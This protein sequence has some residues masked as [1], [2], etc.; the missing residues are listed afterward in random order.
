VL[1]ALAALAIAACGGETHVAT[2]VGSHTFVDLVDALPADLDETGTPDNASTQ[3]VPNWMSELVRTATAA[4]GPSTVLPTG[5]AVVPYLATSWHALANGDYVFELRHAARGA[6]GDPLTAADVRWSLERAVARSPVAPFLFRLARIDS[7]NPVTILSAHSVR[8]NVSGPSPFTLSVLADPDAAIYDSRLMRSHASA[9]DPWAQTW[10]STHSATFGAYYVAT[11]LPNREISLVANPGFWRHPYY[12]HVLIKEVG[13][14]DERV[15]EVLAGTAT[16][17]AGL[18]WGSFGTAVD[19]GPGDGVTATLLQNGPGVISWHLNVRSGPLANPLVRQAINLGIDR[20]ELASGL[21]DAGYAT[22]SVLTIPAAFG[23][24]QP[25][26]INAEQARTLMRSAGYTHAIDVTVYTNDTVTGGSSAVILSTLYQQLLEVD[27][28]LHARI[29]ENT[30][31]LL[32][33]EAS[34]SIESSIGTDTPLLG[35]PAFLV[36]QDANTSIDP[37]SPA[38]DEGYHSAAL[39]S[40]LGQLL[41]AAPGTSADTLTHQAASTLDTDLATINLVSI[42]VQ[43]VTR[44][45]VVGYRASTSAVIYYENLRAA[46]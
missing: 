12:S 31:Q 19:D 27:V 15:N 10:G 38:A 26:L 33:L 37:V 5:G 20:T 3:I 44:S 32:A 35:G 45:N 13:D 18:D 9:H 14:A 42:P 4:P 1:A 21:P 39:S 43:N 29:V 28:T 36:E 17:T 34:H 46:G 24:A 40:T 11:Y 23:Q 30:D 41:D 16:H 8:V 7:A 22:P 6:T 2:T 25:N